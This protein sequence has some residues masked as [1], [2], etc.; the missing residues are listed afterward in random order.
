MHSMSSSQSCFGVG[1]CYNYR[2][3]SP[4]TTD[5]VDM[6]LIAIVGK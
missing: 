2:L 3:E 6:Q 4:C 5:V 1:I